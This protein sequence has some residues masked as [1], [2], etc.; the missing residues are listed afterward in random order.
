MVY[1]LWKGIFQF[2]KKLNIHLHNDSI[3]PSLGIYPREIKTYVHK[4]THNNDHSSFIHNSLKLQTAQVSINRWINIQI[5]TVHSLNETVLG[6]KNELLI[7][8]SQNHYVEWKKPDTK[9]Y[10]Y[11]NPL[12]WYTKTANR[13]WEKS[14]ECF[15]W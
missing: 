4:K 14:G 7:Y 2:R 5:F 3:I 13:W 11:M 9:Y 8:A 1:V 6:G 10:Y 15:L 12:I